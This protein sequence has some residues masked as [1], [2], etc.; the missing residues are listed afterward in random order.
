MYWQNRVGCYFLR[1]FRYFLVYRF[2]FY[3]VCVASKPGVLAGWMHFF[4][5][6]CR[7]VRLRLTLQ[8]FRV[9]D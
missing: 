1:V 7:R 8:H 6:F 3:F 9:R 4:F 2:L 5:S